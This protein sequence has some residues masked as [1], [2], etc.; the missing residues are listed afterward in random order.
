M[1]KID[2]SAVPV[3]TGSIYPQPFQHVVD[4]R[5]KMALGNAAGLTQ[6]GVNLTRLKPGAMSALRHWHEQE[7]EF[8]Y[9]LEG[10][11]VLVEDQGET[12]LKAGDAAGFKA[13]VANGHQLVNRST[14]DVLYL[15]I[16]TRARDERA[17]Y[18]DD[19]LALMRD[20]SGVRLTHKSGEPY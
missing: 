6:F 8:V 19:D 10:E 20:S 16:G 1:P 15:E 12:A 9:I 4:G 13:G 17:H 18:P 14:G 11:A 5:E 2:I 3:R 7:D